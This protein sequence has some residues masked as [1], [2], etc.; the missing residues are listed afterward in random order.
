MEKQPHHK[1]FELGSGGGEPLT[2]DDTGEN[3]MLAAPVVAV[4]TEVYP[5]CY[6]EGVNAHRTVSSRDQD[7]A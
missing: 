6:Q 7:P 1:N 5:V 2:L 3:H 4:F